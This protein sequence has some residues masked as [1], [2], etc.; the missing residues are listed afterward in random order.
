MSGCTEG[1]VLMVV[2][3]LPLSAEEDALI[4]A[5]ADIAM[6]RRWLVQASVAQSAAE[7]LR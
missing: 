6:L 1:E 7:A 2:R 5:C 3:K 4:E